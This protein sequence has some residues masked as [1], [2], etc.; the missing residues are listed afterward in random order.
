LLFVLLLLLS[1]FVFHASR[2]F[3]RILALLGEP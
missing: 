2:F 3:P 1:W